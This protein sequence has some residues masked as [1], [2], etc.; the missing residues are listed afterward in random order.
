MI[1]ASCEEVV[2]GRRVDAEASNF[3]PFHLTFDDGPNAVNGLSL[4]DRL[5][6]FNASATFFY[7]RGTSANASN[8]AVQV[9]LNLLSKERG[10]RA[11]PEHIGARGRM[12]GVTIAA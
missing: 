3:R 5:S 2:R 1:R 7:V 9:G 4:L 6:A 10:G 8:A 12:L 11:T